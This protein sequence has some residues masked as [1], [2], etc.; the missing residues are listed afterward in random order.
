MT[1]TA[2]LHDD[3]EQWLTREVAVGL[4]LGERGLAVPP[5]DALPP[6]PHRHDGLWLT[7]WSFVEHGPAS[8]VP[9]A[10]ELGGSLR[11]LHA[12][13][14]DYPGDLQPV[15]GAR[16][17]IERLLGELQRA[18]RLSSAEIRS[19]RVA[20][21]ELTPT[22]FDPSLPAQALH[23]DVSISNLLRT[24]AGLIWNDLEDVFA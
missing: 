24:D 22:V 11:E 9:A 12:A 2:V 15:T 3:L 14:A 16:A 4:F 10:H 18:G 23:G 17:R 6:G 20:L 7:F 13:L 5:S 19:L 8:P 21:D 1:G